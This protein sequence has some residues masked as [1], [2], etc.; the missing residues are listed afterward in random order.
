MDSFFK[1]ATSKISLFSRKYALHPRVAAASL[2]W[3]SSR[4]FLAHHIRQSEQTGWYTLITYYGRRILPAAKET[5]VPKIGRG[6]I[7]FDIDKALKRFP[8]TKRLGLVFFMGVG[9]Y[10]YASQFIKILHDTFPQLALDAYVSDQ[11]DRNNSPLVA[12]CLENNPCIEHIYMYHGKA[13]HRYWKDYDW[14][15]CYQKASA[16]TLLLP[17]VYEHANF[18]TS[19]TR[20]LCETFGLVPPITNPRP[21]VYDYPLSPR[22]QQFF[23]QYGSSLNKVVFLQCSNRS[24]NF[25]YPYHDELAQK[26][27]DDGYFVVTVE[28][29][30]ITSPRLW[31]VDIKNMKITETVALLQELHRRQIPTYMI[32]TFSCFNSVSSALNIPNLSMQV[33]FDPA[34]GSVMYGNIFL[35]ST[36]IYPQVLSEHQFIAPNGTFTGKN[37][38]DVFKVDFVKQCFDQMLQLLNTPK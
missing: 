4:Q 11:F 29:T 17:V 34:I 25:T 18:I 19:R 2:A 7:Y 1:N 13:N 26:L 5:R 10:F 15:E 33:T 6:H 28:N 8:N 30:A 9:D 12:T 32:T 31:Q 3:W 23:E 22:I 14:S 35:I 38:R 27:L 20:T 37:D 21:L 36:Y 24:F 16:D